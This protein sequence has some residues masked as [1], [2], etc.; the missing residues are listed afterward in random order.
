VTSDNK[1]GENSL[2]VHREKD[3][4]NFLVTPSYNLIN[5]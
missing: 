2:F 3:T 5:E 4:T 1:N